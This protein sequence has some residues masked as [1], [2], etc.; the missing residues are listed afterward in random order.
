VKCLPVLMYGVDACPVNKS[1]LR[2]LDFCQNCT[3]MKIFKT[4]SMEVI[5]ECQRMFS[6]SPMDSAVRQK[7]LKFLRK[8]I[9]ADNSVCKLFEDNARHEQRYLLA[10]LNALSVTNADC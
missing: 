6:L 4:K 2:S 3:L 5:H 7:K 9:C 10:K 1:V 8:F